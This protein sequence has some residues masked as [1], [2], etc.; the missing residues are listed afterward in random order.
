L[1]LIKKGAPSAFL[2]IKAVYKDTEKQ[3]VT[4]KLVEDFL[5]SL[6][7]SPPADDAT[8]EEKAKHTETIVW[9]L[10]FIALHHDY[11]RTRNLDLAFKNIDEA[12]ALDP[13]LPELFMSKAK[14]YKHAGQLKLAA[15]TMNTAR[16]LEKSDRYLNTKCSKY[17]LRTD[18]NEGAL[19]LMSLFTRNEAAGGT[20]GD[21]LE[22]QC[23]WY[24]TEDGEA[25]MR[26]N[27]YGLALKRFTQVWKIFEDWHEDQFDFHSFSLRKGQIRSY[28]AMLRWE[29]TLRHHV[30]FRRAAL[31]AC[32]VYTLLADQPHLGH[33]SLSVGT[34]AE[35][36]ERLSTADKK[37]AMKKAKREQ[38]KEEEKRKEEAAKRKD[39][40]KGKTDDKV[41]DMDP[42]GEELVHSATPLE[43][44]LKFLNPL[45]EF[46]PEFVEVQTAA[47]EVQIRRSKF[48][49]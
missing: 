12:I 6:K 34:L 48:F 37:K 10:Y 40:Q 30:F 19:K 25:Y 20:L 38:Q 5:A 8:E 49:L 7:A 15:E 41:E 2:S 42:K 3:A 14:M 28:I 27:M 22:M 13:S 17:T 26:R 31:N 35:D 24:L 47:F 11:F 43:D 18:D 4:L 45:V 44:A 16:E 32:K 9:T 33:S 46:N 39:E 1:R 29:D 21:L 23:I 36:F